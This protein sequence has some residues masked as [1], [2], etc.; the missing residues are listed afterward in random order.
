M[1]GLGTIRATIGEARCQTM[2]AAAEPPPLS[3][4]ALPATLF[5][6]FFRSGDRQ[7]YEAPWFRR[8]EMLADLALGECLEYQGRFLDPLLNVAWAICEESSWELPAHHH[9]LPD[10]ARPEIGL[11]AALTGTQ[12]AEV[13]VLL[14][15]ECHPLLEQRIRREVDQRLLTPFRRAMISGG[16]I[17]GPDASSTTGP[18]SVWAT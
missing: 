13:V 4:P 1:R 7:Q 11:F 16:C 6:E 2:L 9:D 12:L 3:G 8:R 15:H 18:A 17:P 10:V 14:G 5:L